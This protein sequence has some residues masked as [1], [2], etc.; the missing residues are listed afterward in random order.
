MRCLTIFLLLIVTAGLIS[1]SATNP[2]V[3]NS[4]GLD[5][6]VERSTDES[7]PWV[8]GNWRMYIPED[9]SCIKVVP[10]RSA[11]FHYNVKMLLEQAPCDNCL[12]VSKFVNNG[13]G[14]VTIDISI[15]HPYPGNRYYTGF[16]VRGILFVPPH[17]AFRMAKNFNHYY[18]VFP[19]LETGDP[20]VLN[21]DGYTNAFG[22][23]PTGNPSLLPP[24]L[25][26]QPGGDLG[27]T[28]DNEDKEWIG[29]VELWPYKCYYSSDVRRHFDTNEIVTKTYHIALP[30]GEWE[31]GYS[32]D[33]CWTKPITVP[34]KD[35]E[36]DFPMWANT[37]NHYHIDMFISGPLIG[38]EPSTVTIRLY[39]HFPEVLELYA[40]GDVSIYANIMADISFDNF[41]G[42]TFIN[43]EYVEFKYDLVNEM[44]M[45]PGRY[46]VLAWIYTI[47]NNSYI[48]DIEKYWYRNS[49]CCQIIWVTVES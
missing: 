3:P 41:D 49:K 16:D 9:Q 47:S 26:Y 8:W 42:P 44:Q 1:C 39:N 15:R 40:Y 37:L 18:R 46:P 36:T 11:D 33:A 24:I 34:V 45:P 31:F 20:E 14:T 28:Y 38:L 17:Y 13:D 35:I 48:D 30:P 21:P 32:V 22:P 7:N 19:A 4:P 2:A 10:V 6:P 23:F 27:G 25:K 12:W 5:E 43:D 29:S